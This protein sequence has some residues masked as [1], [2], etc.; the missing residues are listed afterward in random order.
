MKQT[1]NKQSMWLLVITMTAMLGV[2]LKAQMLQP[3]MLE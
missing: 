3:Y 2:D 1:K